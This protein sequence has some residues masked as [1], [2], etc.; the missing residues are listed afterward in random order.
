MPPIVSFDVVYM[1][2]RKH[3]LQDASLLVRDPVELF[4]TLKDAVAQDLGVH[5][6]EIAGHFAAGEWNNVAAGN[7][8]PS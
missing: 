7:S 8:I 2:V 6:D 4:E 3:L 5:V 1:S